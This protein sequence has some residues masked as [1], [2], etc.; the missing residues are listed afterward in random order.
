MKKY[1]EVIFDNSV[2]MGTRYNQSTRMEVAKKLFTNKISALMDFNQDIVALRTL[3][4]T[5]DSQSYR[6]IYDTEKSMTKAINDL[7]PLTQTP[8]FKTIKDAIEEGRKYTDY[9]K[10]IFVITDGED[11][12]T[13]SLESVISEEDQKLI[14]SWNILLMKFTVDC[15]TTR[16][17]LDYLAHYLGGTSFSVGSA[18]NTDYHSLQL[19]FEIGLQISNIRKETQIPHCYT[20]KSGDDSTWKKIENEGILFFNAQ[21]LYEENFLSWEP[22]KD[23]AVS[24]L[25]KAELSFLYG[26]RF[27][28]CLPKENVAV[29]LKQLKKPYYYSDECIYWD[30]SQTKW[31]RHVKKLI[32]PILNNPTRFM[33][34][35]PSYI[36]KY[37]NKM[38]DK[39]DNK[40]F[41]DGIQAKEFYENKIYEV[42]KP[43]DFT[44]EEWEEKLNFLDYTKPKTIKLRPGQKVEF[45]SP[46]PRGR[47][48]GK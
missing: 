5:C 14:K 25:Q 6:T 13:D 44:L 7:Y 23:I 1:I 8:L 36:Q 15:L 12:C 41:D 19:E 31:F 26:L 32:S 22:Q 27:H 38:F 37:E 17:N 11:S 33:A 16:G 21:L 42:K 4:P 46:K 43:N 18:P 40:L 3:R 39:V 24:A 35:D 30:F 2:S 20:H 9:E 34:D 10:M 29:M 45:I 48:K 47:K 28:S